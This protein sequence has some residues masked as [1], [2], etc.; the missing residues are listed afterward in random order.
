MKM[1]LFR[2]G[3]DLPVELYA[4]THVWSLAWSQVGLFRMEEEELSVYYKGGFSNVFC[5][6]ARPATYP[7]TT[8]TRVWMSCTLCFNTQNI[9]ERILSNHCWFLGARW[10]S[11]ISGF[12]PNLGIFLGFSEI[13]LSHRSDRI[14][15]GVGLGY[16]HRPPKIKE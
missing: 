3:T 8:P 7:C 15:S 4:R 16:S 14:P 2:P 11:R 9:V 1:S 13:F 6:D 5:N 12:R 10:Q